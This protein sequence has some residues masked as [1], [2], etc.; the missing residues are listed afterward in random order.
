MLDVLLNLLTLLGIMI[1]GSLVLV[2]G[3]TIISVAVYLIRCAFIGIA[4]LFK[5]GGKK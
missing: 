4:T 2:V 1:V 3:I 5:K